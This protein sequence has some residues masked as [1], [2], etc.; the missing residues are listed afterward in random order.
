MA[1]ASRPKRSMSSVALIVLV[2]VVLSVGMMNFFA[3]KLLNNRL[4]LPGPMGG[5]LQSMSAVERGA[6][7]FTSNISSLVGVTLDEAGV[8]TL[9]RPENRAVLTQGMRMVRFFLRAD[10][11]SLGLTDL[12]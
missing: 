11:A 2:S 6:P 10:L 7:G 9:Y 1:L 12:V 5:S 4:G 3:V 8:S